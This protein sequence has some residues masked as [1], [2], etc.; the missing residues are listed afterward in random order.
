[1]VFGLNFDNNSILTKFMEQMAGFQTS[2]YFSWEFE[3]LE[4]SK[5]PSF[6]PSLLLSES[7]CFKSLKHVSIK[8]LCYGFTC[9]ILHI[10]I[11]RNY[12]N[13]PW[14]QFL[15]IPDISMI[16]RGFLLQS[17]F[18]FQMSLNEQIRCHILKYLFN[19]SFHRIFHIRKFRIRCKR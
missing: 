14:R 13:G 6:L 19:V 12:H 11:V 5:F 15:R 4:I 17:K 9:H 7:L 2:F 1:M 3:E 10:N 8:H 16:F 18:T